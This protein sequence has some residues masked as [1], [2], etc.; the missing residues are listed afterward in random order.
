MTLVRCAAAAVLASSAA[1]VL[2]QRRRASV[3]R[4]ERRRA[5]LASSL[6][7]GAARLRQL[8]AIMIAAVYEQL[9]VK[10]AN[11]GRTGLFCKLVALPISQM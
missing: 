4:E 3:A 10:L 8:E 2:R 11:S 6:C 9:V 1:V 5:V 7:S